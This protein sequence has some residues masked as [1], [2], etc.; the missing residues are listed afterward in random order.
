M[1]LRVRG[2]VFLVTRIFLIDM[3][4]IDFFCEERIA[5]AL[6]AAAELRLFEDIGDNLLEYVITY[7]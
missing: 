6:E 4:D 7:K 1:E 5:G 3:T 2:N